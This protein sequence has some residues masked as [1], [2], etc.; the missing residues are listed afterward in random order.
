MNNT[1]FPSPPKTVVSLRNVIKSY[2]TETSSPV[3]ALREV[4]VDIHRGQFTAIMGPS[5]SGKSTFMNIGAGLDDVT[6]GDCFLAGQPL[7]RMDDTQRTLLRREAVGFIF[8]AFNL[9]PTLSAQENIEL[10]FELSGRRIDPDTR[11]WI[12]H[13]LGVLGLSE[14][15]G[16]RPAQL[17]GGQQQRVAIARALATRPAIIFADEPTGNLDTRS[18]R[19]VLTLLR[20]AVAEYGQTIAMVT[21]DPVAASHADRV[22]VIADGRIVRDAPR[23]TA[24]EISSLM[25]AIEGDAA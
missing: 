11:A 25:L 5:G 23:M 3:H 6:Q 17:S 2:G 15:A 8:Q 10:P 1:Q 14:R 9:V 21:H 22:I 12:G 4:T 16:H 20:T 18:S 13:L 7:H 24:S 19:E